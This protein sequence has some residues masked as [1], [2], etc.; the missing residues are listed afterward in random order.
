MDRARPDSLPE[1]EEHHVST[2]T[3]AYSANQVGSFLVRK[4]KSALL[5]PAFLCTD[6]KLL[7]FFASALFAILGM[8]QSP[9]HLHRY[10]T[11]TLPLHDRYIAVTL[12]L[13]CRYITVT[14]PLHYRYQRSVGSFAPRRACSSWPTRR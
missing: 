7:F 4:L 1:A 11:V 12:P 2:R 13:H 14:L 9:F 10:I 3:Y 6:L 8:V 5:S